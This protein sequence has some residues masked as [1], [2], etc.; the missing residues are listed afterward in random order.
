MRALGLVSLAMLVTGSFA[1]CGGTTDPGGGAAP[2]D[3]GANANDAGTT[4]R[5]D[6]GQS[7]DA[8]P[9][10]PDGSDVYPADHYPLPTMKNY[11][12]PVMTDMKIITVTFVGDANRDEKRAFDDMILATPWWD[13]VTRG[14][15][16]HRGSG[17]G[18]VELPDTVSNQTIDNDTQLIPML[19]KLVTDGKL[20]APDANTIYAVYF[21]QST[22]IALEG[23]S[24]CQ[25][26]GAYHD[27]AHFTVAGKDVMGAFAVLPD[28]GNGLSSGATSH[29]LIEAATDP[30][31]FTSLHPPDAFSFYL[32]NDA[33]APAGGYEVADMC[34]GLK[35]ATEGS[36]KVARS[37]VNAA[38]LE[39]KD[40][41]QPS[42]P[43]LLYFNASVETEVVTG[44]HDPTGGPDYD[45]GGFVI[46]KAGATKTANVV[47]FSEAKLPHDL[48]L[49]VGKPASR[50][51]PTQVS[52]IATGVDAT[53]S[54]TTARNGTHLTL[55]ITTDATTQPGDYKFVVR[56]ILEQNDYHSWPVV[57]R[58]Q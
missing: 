13:S 51:D 28:C 48:S 19:Q 41:C 34:E 42:D 46:V 4:P 18:Y 21:P 53:L 55:T 14:Y 30:H 23:M 39:S 11:G 57:L 27:Y 16:I 24:S 5:A 36:Y 35:G 38:A 3:G 56:A 44:L 47:V 22:T 49:V 15:G 37:W 1:A 52:A 40:P 58:V 20:P 10:P 32:Y 31:P 26:Y 6:A 29:E 33:W 25:G 45:G 43:S 17:G 7:A 9:P 12:G 2:A 54:Q 50:S 8:A